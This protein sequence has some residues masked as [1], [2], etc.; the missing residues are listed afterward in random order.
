MD[1]Y[2]VHTRYL[3]KR[4]INLGGELESREVVIGGVSTSS[5]QYNLG[6]CGP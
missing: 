5:L 2:S 4:E 1:P 6:E 3:D